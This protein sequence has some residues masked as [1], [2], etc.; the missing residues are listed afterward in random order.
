MATLP[1]S[2]PIHNI[3]RRVHRIHVKRHKSPIHSLLAA[4]RDV[5]PDRIKIIRYAQ[6]NP[7]QKN[8]F[9]TVIAKNRDE[10]IQQDRAESEEVKMYMDGSGQERRIEAVAIM[11]KG[12][13]RKRKLQL[14]MG[15]D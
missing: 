14:S 5:K 2:I 8:N 11:K 9:T 15:T 12:G 10:A 6:C 4:C 7:Q 13:Q 1:E 3:I